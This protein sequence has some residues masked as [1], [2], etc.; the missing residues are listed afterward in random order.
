MGGYEEVFTGPRSGPASSSILADV[1][2]G[3]FGKSTSRSSDSP[4]SEDIPAVFYQ[5]NS[6]PD[7]R[8]SQN[9]EEQGMHPNLYIKSE[10]YVRS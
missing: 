4:Y 1:L 3:S 2:D 10:S 8:P 6:S 9:I 5:N 7:E